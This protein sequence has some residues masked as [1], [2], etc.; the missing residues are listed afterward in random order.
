MPAL[1]FVDT[2]IDTFSSIF[3]PS[4]VSTA[5]VDGSC[6]WSP[7]LS[8][9]LYRIDGWGAPYFAAN[10]SGNISV[11]PHGSNTLP[12]QDIDL[13][14]VVKKVTDP[15]GLGL[16]LPLIVR[17][18]DVLKNRL[19]CLQSAFDYA[20]QSQ[21]YDSHYQGVYP[22]KC[23]QDRFI[24][25]DI[26]E[27]GSGF[28][29]GLEAG[30]KPEILLAMSCL[31]KGNP[32]AFLVCNGFKDS[33][34]ISL[35]LFGRKLELNTVIVLEQEEEL[36]LVIDLSQKMNVRPVIGLR[37]KL[38]TKH[39]GHFG[40]TSGEKG[41]FGLTTVQILRVVRKLS[42]VGMLDCLQLLH[43][44]IGSQIPSTALLSDG[45]A[46][47]AQLYC[48]LVRLGAHMK[49]IDIG[50]GLGIDYDGSKSGES[51]LSVAYSL[52]EY[53][54]AVVASVR[55]VCDQKSVK[56][57]VICSESGR[58][59]VSHHSV[60]IF[61]AVSAGQ[62]HET[63]T[64]HQFML[65]GYSEEVRGDYENLY[66]AAMRGDRESCLLYVDQLKQRCV[67]GFKE[68]SLGI[69]QLAG[70]DGLCE[71]V[72]KAIGAS[73]PVLTYHVNLSVFTSIPDFWGIDQLFPIVPI[74]KLDQRP[75]ARGILSDLTCDS[76][77]KINK[78]IGGES[79]LPLHEMD[80]NGCSGGRYYLGMFLGGAYEEALGGVHN[81]FGGPSVVRVLQSDGPHGFA[82]TRAVMGQSSADVLRAMQHEPEL[83]FQTL[84]HRAEEPRNN[85]NKACGDKGNDKLVVASCLAK[86]FNN[87]PYLS[88]ETSTNALT[89][90]VN[91]LGVYYCDEAAAG[92]GGKGKDENWSYF[93]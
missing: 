24:I 32:E 92:G 87:M 23:N 12:H 73:D 83:M 76:D 34:Y 48:E 26:V 38:R 88:M 1:A 31:C 65:E 82:V 60:L 18:P 74:H 47:A 16:Q 25:E 81:L 61:E 86:S 43:F 59:I 91:N 21:G 64:D 40:S 42:Q 55:F 37:A 30:S 51:D 53:A 69:E 80:N 13:M 33:E 29:F 19:E 71:W 57:P 6:H 7:S 66:G 8:S 44:H 54:A 15:S 89:A 22:V 2:P 46:E 35:A 27:F 63:P 84:K 9:S 85:N 58:A 79:S 14:K 72:I 50:G 10:S 5:V 45:V 41:K 3:T 68:G 62:Q 93:G 75:A 67:E 28:R 90:A 77:G 17:F 39:S 4:S 70:V 20:I 52:E 56:H 11:R 78:F 49:V 36:D